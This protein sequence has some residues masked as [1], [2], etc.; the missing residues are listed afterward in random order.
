VGGKFWSGIDGSGREV[1]TSMWVGRYGGHFGPSFYC[2]LCT[3][4]PIK[5]LDP[6][7]KNWTVPEFFGTHCKW[8]N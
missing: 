5:I 4:R 1:R 7:Q 3:M 2:K 8:C 6:S